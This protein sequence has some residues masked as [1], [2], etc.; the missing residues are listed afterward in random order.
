MSLSLVL[1]VLQEI[2]KYTPDFQVVPRRRERYR[3]LKFLVQGLHRYEILIIW[4]HRRKEACLPNF[5]LTW[6]RRCANF[7]PTLG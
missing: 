6:G 2:P 5:R 7:G 3:I 1:Q 4:H